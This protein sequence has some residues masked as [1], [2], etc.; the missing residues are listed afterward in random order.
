[1][2]SFIRARATALAATSAAASTRRATG[3]RC[4]ARST[5]SGN[6][7]LNLIRR[8]PRR[9]PPR[10][11]P[12]FLRRGPRRPP[13]RPPPGFR[14]QSPRSKRDDSHPLSIFHGGSG[15]PTLSV[16]STY[17]PATDMPRVVGELMEFVG[18][19]EGDVAA[20]RRSAG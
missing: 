3:R 2:C 9:P 20:I 19:D 6:T 11:P 16:M 18:L 14:G 8:G 10:P 1:R 5:S 12:G 7:S 15:A 4:S 13:P 17:L